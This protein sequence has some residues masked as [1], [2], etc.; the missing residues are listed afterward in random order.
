MRYRSLPLA[1]FIMLARDIVADIRYTIIGASRRCDAHRA[2]YDL[3]YQLGYNEG[4]RV[5]RPVL[6]PDREAR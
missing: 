5:G 6:V 4:R 1:P 3:G 2:G